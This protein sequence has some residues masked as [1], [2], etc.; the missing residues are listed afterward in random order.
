MGR[1]SSEA[2][3]S[4]ST[5]HFSLLL[6]VHVQGADLGN[7]AVTSS[8]EQVAVREELDGLDTL[9]EE[10]LVGS[11]SLEGVLLDRDLDDVTS[12]G[13]EVGVGVG[14]IND[15]AGENT[16]D[17]VGQDLVVLHLLLDE[18]QVPG[19]NAVVVH[20]EAL[21]GRG[22]EEGN[23]VS[24]VHANWVSDEGLATLDL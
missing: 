20:G 15:A 8:D 22:V 21:G 19:S 11:D 14:G 13:A 12:L 10:L 5:H 24:D 2:D 18:V 4:D 23:L 1:V 3:G 7:G 9:L 17:L 16:L 6:H